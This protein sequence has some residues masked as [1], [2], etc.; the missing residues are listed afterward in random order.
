MANK[1]YHKHFTHPIIFFI[2]SVFVL[3]SLTTTTAFFGSMT[4]PPTSPRH[5][6]GK[7]TKKE[8][9]ALLHFKSYIRYDPEGRL[10]T[11]TPGEEEKVATNDCCYWSGVTCNNHSRVISLDLRYGY[12]EGKIGP[13]LLN[14]SY[15]Y[16][17]DLS[18]NSFNGTI[19]MFI[20]SMTQLRYLNL[21]W[22]GFS[23]TIPMFIGSMT[24]LRYL[25]LGWNGF[26]GTIPM[27][28]GSMT[29]LRYLNLG[30]NGFSGTI[31]MFIGSMTQLRY[32][33]LG[34][35]G[36][37][38]TI[39]SELGNLTN[40][41]ELYL[42][43]LSN[44]TIENL[45][46]LS[47]LSQLD[48]L[49]MSGISLGKV[50]N[51]VNVILSLKKLSYLSLNGCDLSHVMHPYS[52]SYVN[53]SFSSSIV[54]LYLSGNNLN[55]S[56]YHWLFPL[57][58]NALE[59][60]DLSGNMLDG[61][62]K[63]LGNL[64]GLTSL[65][66]Y[67]NLMPIKLPD[68]LSNLSGCTSVTLQYLDASC[69]Q[70]TGSLSDDIQNFSSL[71][72]LYLSN[73][74]L[75]GTISE[76]VWQ[77][78]K[79]QRLD[80]SYNFLKG[81]ISENIEKSNILYVYL[82]N[83]SLEGVPLEANMSNISSIEVIDLSSCKLGPHFP[84]W[85]QT[86]K[87][88]SGIDL[89]N[90]EI[91]D[92]IPEDFWK[93]WPSR[94]RDLHISSNN[95]YGHIRN[96]PS[97]LKRLD[98]SKNNLSGQIF[99][100]CQIVDGYLSFLDLSHNAFTGPIPDCLWNFTRLQILSLGNNNLSGRLPTSIKFLINLEVLYLYNNS[101]SGKLPLPLKNLTHLTFLNFGGNNFS[102]YVPGWIGERLS[103]LYALILTSNKFIGTI[104]SHL[105]QLENLQIL[106]LSMN[107]L[108]GAIPSCLG[109]LNSMVQD[110]LAE[111]Q[112][113]HS[114]YGTADAYVDRSMIKWQGSLREF[115]TTLGLVK[116]INLSSN[117]L[118]GKIPDKLT[119]LHKLI[120][121][122]LSMN[123]LVGEIPSNIGQ[124]KALLI[125]DLSRNNLRGGLPSSM[126]QMTLLNY[127]DV[128]YNSLSGRIPSST[129]LQS[130]EPS[131]YTGNAGLCGLPLTKYCPGDKVLEGPPV[132]RESMEGGE[133]I[134][135]L[136]RWFYIG[137][138][139][140][141]VTGFWMVCI[142]LI[143]NLRGR[144]AFFHVMN[145]LE[146]WVYV[147]IMVFI[148]KVRRVSHP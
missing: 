74:K 72:D 19:P 11:W 36:F 98:L 41:Q 90:T 141:F 95:L 75:D 28:I 54:T 33:N 143:V 140:G 148:A 138:A 15:L 120:A 133:G 24:Q 7:C 8:R 32:L 96:V 77:L 46:W 109:N 97:S 100:L 61:I 79:L 101:F 6:T 139:S 112:N 59:Y 34:L 94:L 122:D 66:F 113:V 116:V 87:N 12:L 106:D 132:S 117:D 10:T 84:K 89:S 67:I 27:F 76:K 92:N 55:S 40:L 44:C 14:L 57:T 130:F 85:I 99:F 43:S 147:K 25:N 18:R 63:Y 64:C 69:S 42:E 102:G 13:S 103:S 145:S 65:Y 68:F 17:L 37:R 73:N 115:G 70:F 128:S 93:T 30:W 82:S 124:M 110:G 131:R 60:L 127:L 105:C 58:S 21:G 137:G 119:D 4:Q 111:S 86:M 52:Y 62:P 125:L 22:N 38:G 107:K 1:I 123:A 49:D 29:Q 71:Q 114:V 142:A 136:Q 16:Y 80:I 134:D 121:L 45:D 118:T 51:W 31:P 108:Q 91:S 146:N 144:H 135:D 50:D 88:L 56:M 39:P 2:A 126:S 47:H 81:A 53:S 23:G 5:R 83:N 104:P 26:S 78:P 9:Q 129:Q 20:G 48:R 3:E 35:N